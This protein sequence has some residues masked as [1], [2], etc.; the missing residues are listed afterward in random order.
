MR[1]DVLGML[2][3]LTNFDMDSRLVLSVV[4]AGQPPLAKL[5]QRPELDSVARRRVHYARLQVL[6]RDDTK[7]CLRHRLAVAGASALP[8]DDPALD[9]IYELGAGNLRATDRLALRSLELAAR[10]DHDVVGSEHVAGARQ[11]LWA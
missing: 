1:P 3:I 7:R 8:F 2:R 5:L 11:T 6:S 9:A 4:I 10:S